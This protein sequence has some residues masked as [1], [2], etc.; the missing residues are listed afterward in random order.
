MRILERRK[1]RSECFIIIIIESWEK[2]RVKNEININ[3]D[4][5]ADEGSEDRYN[6]NIDKRDN[7]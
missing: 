4:N 1:K 2:E 7:I 3:I 5:K 6:L